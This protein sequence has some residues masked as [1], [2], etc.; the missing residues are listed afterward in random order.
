MKGENIVSNIDIKM[1]P[2]DKD[3]VSIQRNMS[4]C[5]KCNMCKDICENETTVAR[6]YELDKSRKPICINCGQ[7]ANFCPT[8]AIKEKIEFDKVKEEIKDPN[9]V[10]IVSIAPAVRVALGEEFGLEEGSYVENKIIGVLRK[11]GANYVF[12][13]TFGADL[14]IMEEANELVKRIKENKNLPLFT[15][16]CPAWVKYAEIFYPELLPNIS[17]CK[18][19]IS[20]QGSII[21]TYFANKME[22]SH[23]NIVNVVV[24]PC[25][26]KKYE[27]R[28]PEMNMAGKYLNEEQLRD[29]DYVITTRELAE[30]IKEEN[31][32]F[33]EIKPSKFDNPLGRGTGASIIFGNTGGVTEAA[34]RTA[35]YLITKK[36]LSD[37][38]IEFKVARGMEGI[39]EASIDIDGITIKVAIANGMKNAKI[40]IDKILAKEVE[41]HFIE[42]MNCKGGCIAGGGQPKITLANLEN[43]RLKRI[44][45][46]YKK[47]A[48]M[49][50]R[51]SYKNPDI[52]EIYKEF[53][54]EPLS[55]ISEE[56]LHT[57][58]ED[59]SYMLDRT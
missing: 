19:P 36:D 25:T 12:D 9:K 52:I 57:K 56:L 30:W 35:Y 53:L 8:E 47:D 46:L 18:S 4:K 7:C 50:K 48:S 23:K 29:N 51:L 58:Y 27:I 37:D 59:K 28:R 21:K 42:I 44:E 38:K 32:N 3:N 55:E 54:K 40:L 1:V 14:T 16:C 33:D 10:V 39:K 15:S 43:A 49:E 45:S 6:M 26:A 41:Y 5:I 11:L 34:L 2:I 17:T 31:I 24:A 20:M 22:I 13:I